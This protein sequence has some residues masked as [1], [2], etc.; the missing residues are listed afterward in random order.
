[1]L[2]LGNLEQAEQ[3]LL[4]AQWTVMKTPEC[5][6]TMKHKLSRH[7]GLLYAA[8]TQFGHALRQLAYDVSKEHIHIHW[9][10]GRF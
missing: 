3:Y 4:Q 6:N 1:V 2:G 8:K 5:P 9:Q 10:Q 7:L